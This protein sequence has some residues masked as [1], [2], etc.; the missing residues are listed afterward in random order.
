MPMILL[1]AL[2]IPVAAIVVTSAN[3]YLL[4]PE[5]RLKGLTDKMGLTFLQHNE[6]RSFFLS[7]GLVC[8]TFITYSAFN[9]V[10]NHQV[11]NE[12][13]EELIV[14]KIEP[15]NTIIP[16]ISTPQ[17]AQPKAEV[18]TSYHK[19][20]ENKNIKQDLQLSDTVSNS[21]QIDTDALTYN[22]IPDEDLSAPKTQAIADTNLYKP[23]ENEILSNAQFKG[24][25]IE[26]KKF[27]QNNIRFPQELIDKK[28]KGIVYISLIVD[29]DGSINNVKVLKG[30]TYPAFNK[31]VLRVINKMPNWQPALKNDSSK[32]RQILILPID[33][34]VE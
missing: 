16:Q 15:I 13:T 23:F 25:L 5:R 24:G 3:S 29:A 17:P 10:F 34:D 1:L 7:F 19:P 21:R 9:T 30:T 12:N 31:E 27:L 14:D 33:F 11:P 20:V 4:G 32:V 26:G 18:T 8:S 28:A 2:S 22:D 6:Y